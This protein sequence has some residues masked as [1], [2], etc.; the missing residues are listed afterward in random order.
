MRGRVG[1]PPL[2]A[3]DT[4]PMD[5]LSPNGNWANWAGDQR[6]RPAK[7]LAPRT[8]EELAE[9]VGTAAAA[10]EKLSVTG[11]GHSFTEAA[12]TDQT[13][14]RLDPLRG[15]LDADRESGLVKVGA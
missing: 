2:R 6:C 1:R 13:M 10:G 14:L 3:R 8:R 11:S 7:V 12:M 15:V 4:P 9:V 5:P